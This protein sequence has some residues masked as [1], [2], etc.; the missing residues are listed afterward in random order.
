MIF[1]MVNRSQFVTG[2]QMLL[3]FD[4]QLDVKTEE[5]EIKSVDVVA[6]PYV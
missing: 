4:Y 3:S 1:E 2:S 5:R 6:D